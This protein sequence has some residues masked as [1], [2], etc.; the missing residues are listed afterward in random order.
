MLVTYCRLCRHCHSLAGGACLLSRFHFTRCLYFLG[1]VACWNLPWQGLKVKSIKYCKICRQLSR[2]F[3][4]LIWRLGETVQNRESPE[5]SGRNDNT[6][7]VGKI[8]WFC[9]VILNFILS[10]KQINLKLRNLSN[11][12]AF[13][14]AMLIDFLLSKLLLVRSW[15]TMGGSNLCCEAVIWSV[16]KKLI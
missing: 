4:T 15:K 1:H 6:A 13:F 7:K 10:F 2:R 16:N 9:W 3:Q 12:K 8:S 5:L 11:F 14:A